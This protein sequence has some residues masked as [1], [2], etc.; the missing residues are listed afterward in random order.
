MSLIGRE[1]TK[2]P[3]VNHSQILKF[4]ILWISST[5]FFYIEIFYLY[6]FLP[7]NFSLQKFNKYPGCLIW[8]LEV[9]FLQLNW[10]TLRTIY[11]EFLKLEF[12]IKIPKTEI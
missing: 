12:L 7:L 11:F 3:E 6:F 2:P 8:I 1:T 10:S 4:K 5:E 9:E